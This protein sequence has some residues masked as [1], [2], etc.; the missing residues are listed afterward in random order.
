MSCTYSYPTSHTVQKTF[1][2]IHW[3]NLGPEGNEYS[4]RVEYLGDMNKDSTFRIN[5]LRES[6]SGT[7]RFRFLTDPDGET[8]FGKSGIT[9]AV[10]DLQVMVNPDTVTE[11]QSVRLTCSTTCTLTG[12]PA[13]IWYRDGSPL[14]FTDQSHQ[15]TASSE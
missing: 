3:K 15:F 6:D 5:Q 12:S 13:F 8:Y 9:L 11:G 7:Y 2:F 10:T 14:S 1:W 4:D